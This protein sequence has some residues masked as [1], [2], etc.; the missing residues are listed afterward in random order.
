VLVENG[1]ADSGSIG[2]LVHAR[3]VV[4]TVYEYL[5]GRDEQLA[6]TFVAREP[7]ATPVSARGSA[8]RAVT[9]GRLCASPLGSAGEI[10][11]SRPQSVFF[12]RAVDYRIG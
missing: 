6:A 10:A 1:F 9:V 3:C 12:W 7:V 11:H 2:D 8:G 5:A 4:A